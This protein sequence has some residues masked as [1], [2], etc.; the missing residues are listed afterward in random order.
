MP[1]Y[2]ISDF[3]S[4]LNV[5]KKNRLKTLIIAPPSKIV[6]EFLKIF[7]N[8]GIIR[9]YQILDNYKIE[10][11]LRYNR[12]RC[13]FIHLTVLSKPSKRVY[14]TLIKLHKLK[15]KYPNDILL[16]STSKGLM[17]DVECLEQKKGGLV[18]LRITA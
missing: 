7:E 11:F 13:A 15:E 12:G 3:I 9:G 14:V 10:I 17:L 2:I 5:A 1:N 4:R 18:L 16:L 8:L 6:L